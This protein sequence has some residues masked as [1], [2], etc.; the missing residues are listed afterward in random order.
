MTSNR[1]DGKIA[2]VTGGAQGIGAAIVATFL[3]EGAR[4]I[5]SDIN[6]AAGQAA[7]GKAGANADFIQHDVASEDDWRR[8]IGDTVSQF[9]GLDILVNNAAITG[10]GVAGQDGPVADPENT[11]IENW[12][13]IHRVNAEGPFLGC[14]H[15]IP[16]MRDSGGGSIVNISSGG[17]LI[18]S[19]MNTP[20]GAAKSGLRNLTITVAI[21]CGLKGYNIRCNAVFPGA[22]RTAMLEGLFEVLAAEAQEAGQV[23]VT[24][25]DVASEWG[26]QSPLGR[27][28]EPEDIANAVLFLAS[29][30]SSYITA[31][32]LVVDGGSRYPTFLSEDH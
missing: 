30:E 19:P 31:E 18:P 32:E 2:I 9:G 21:H 17:A 7:A 23:G 20:Y 6:E 14:K 8:V 28:A 24:A 10:D 27:L 25:K 3:R 11:T 26:K 15:A 1:L 13:A 12:R 22:T 4:V 16:A 5:I 29:D